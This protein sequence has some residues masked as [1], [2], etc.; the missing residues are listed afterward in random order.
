MGRQTFLPIRKPFFRRARIMWAMFSKVFPAFRTDVIVSLQPSQHWGDYGSVPITA[1]P[2][3][4]ERI[5]AFDERTG[6]FRSRIAKGKCG[7][8]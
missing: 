2:L 5:N 4:R 7:C 8:G 6:N 3:N 1:K